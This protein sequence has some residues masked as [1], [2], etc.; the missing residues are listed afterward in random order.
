[1]K[2]KGRGMM[3]FSKERMKREDLNWRRN[4]GMNSMEE[5]C[6]EVE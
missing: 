3:G 5:D 1:M 4:V 6:E 2:N